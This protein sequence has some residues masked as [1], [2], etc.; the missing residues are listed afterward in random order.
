MVINIIRYTSTLNSNNFVYTI[1]HT[2]YKRSPASV[3]MESPTQMTTG[4]W[5]LYIQV[6]QRGSQKRVAAFDLYMLLR[7]MV[8]LI[9][10]IPLAYCKFYIIYTY[11]EQLY[12]HKRGHLYHLLT[13]RKLQLFQVVMIMM[14]G[15]L[16]Q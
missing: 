1:M 11:H 14:S 3:R 13:S 2:I 7:T 9:N 12:I 10:C 5:S 16:S 8:L 4:D 6:L 15:Q